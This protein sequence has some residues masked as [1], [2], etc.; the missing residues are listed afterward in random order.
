MDHFKLSL[1]LS[2]QSI[3]LFRMNLWCNTQTIMTH[4][5]FFIF[6]LFKIIYLKIYNLFLPNNKK[7]VWIIS[8][9][10]PHLFFNGQQQTILATCIEFYTRNQGPK[11]DLTGLL[12]KVEPNKKAR[13]EMQ[14]SHYICQLLGLRKK[15]FI[16]YSLASVIQFPSLSQKLIGP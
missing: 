5:L 7:Q 9:P 15:K 10:L 14:K 12:F 4:L 8:N 16:R 6:L 1:S 2:N 11:N 13:S 3:C